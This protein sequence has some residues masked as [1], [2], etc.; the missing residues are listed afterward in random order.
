ME[1]YTNTSENESMNNHQISVGSD[2]VK[3]DISKV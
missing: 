3:R 2:D 1:E